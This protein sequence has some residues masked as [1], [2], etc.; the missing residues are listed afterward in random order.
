LYPKNLSITSGTVVIGAN[1]LE[2]KETL[3]KTGGTID[4][5]AGDITFSGT[6]AQTLPAN[7]FVNNTV[8]KLILNN[9]AGL[10]LGGAN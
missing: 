4:A 9:T 2:V 1:G 10:T 5:T 6:A 8:E 3:S 7:F